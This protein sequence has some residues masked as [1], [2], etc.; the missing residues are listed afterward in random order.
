MLTLSHFLSKKFLIASFLFLVLILFSSYHFFQQGNAFKAI[1]SCNCVVFRLD[2]I[3]Y[4]DAQ[5]YDNESRINIDL[6]VMNVFITKNQSVSL[7]LVMHF[8][9]LH[10]ILLKN[11]LDGYSKGLFELALHG[12]DH[13]DYSNLSEIEQE[14]SL[15]KANEKMVN[16]FGKPSTIFI[17]PYNLFN[18]TTLDAMKKLGITIISS[19]TQD[20]TDYDYFI[21]NK[22]SKQDQIYHMPQMTSF[23]T[24]QGE[25]PIRIPV[26]K[27]LKDID[28][29]IEKYGY[30]IIILHPQSFMKIKK[31]LQNDQNAFSEYREILKR[32]EVIDKHQIDRLEFLIQSILAKDI[33]ITSFSKL[34]ELE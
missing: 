20:D 25:I 15:R 10:S 31:G 3:P 28:Y 17:P 27:I 7:G 2:D 23:E 30:A 22:T 18:V 32:T 21:P 4:D 5:V 12:W 13:V 8:I 9:D 24:F 19:S 1:H 29:N 11:V 33:R 16:L 26:K 34:L 6:A 14:A